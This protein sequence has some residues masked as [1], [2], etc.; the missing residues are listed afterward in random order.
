MSLRAEHVS[1]S[2]FDGDQTT[3]AVR[4]ISLSLPE[5][6]FFGIMGPSGSGK[7]SLLYLLNGLKRPTSGDVLYDGKSLGRMGEAERVRLRRERFGFVFQQPFLLNYLTARENILLAAPR[8]DRS[9][10]RLVDALLEEL[11]ILSLRDRYPA[12]LSGGE[13]QRLIVARALINRPNIVFADEPTAS[14]DHA[15][16]WAV[17]ELLQ[18]YRDRGVVLVVTHD[19][20][21]VASADRIFHL[22]DGHLD[23]VEE[24]ALHVHPPPLDPLS[25]KGRGG[26]TG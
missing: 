19:P 14:L 12:H 25:L 16:G 10:G 23:S 6:G 8:A 18:R 11:S 1:L 15:N 26:T 2:Y 9:A 22:T 4:D 17:I 3:Y 21:M 13:R 24:R 20:T 7:S 5:R